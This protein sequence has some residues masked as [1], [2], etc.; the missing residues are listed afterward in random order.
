MPPID[1]LEEWV[2]KLI[3]QLELKTGEFTILP[4]YGGIL[5]YIKHQ[6]ISWIPYKQIKEIEHKIDGGKM[7]ESGVALGS[8]ALITLTGASAIP[9]LIIPGLLKGWYRTIAKPSPK[10]QIT[11]LQS[12]IKEVIIRET[13]LNTKWLD[14]F[15]KKSMKDQK[16]EQTEKIEV[17]TDETQPIQDIIK[18][19]PNLDDNVKTYT[20]S[21]KNKYFS[22]NEIDNKILRMLKYL[23]S[24]ILGRE[25]YE[26]AVLPN[27]D[28]KKFA[29]ILESN[30]IR[31]VW[32]KMDKIIEYPKD[33]IVI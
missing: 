29:D 20:I 14:L 24:G 12:I 15:E 5:L 10:K 25:V 27:A 19:N 11:Y 16:K 23:F 6:G 18:Y 21:I 7:V 8:I 2:I 17:E 4:S 13:K 31:V 32:K 26:F 30:N 28:V 3:E 33:G 9:F 22:K 1:L